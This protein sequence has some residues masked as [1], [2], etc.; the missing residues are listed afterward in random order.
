MRIF[1]VYANDMGDGYQL[2]LDV[3]A[4]VPVDIVKK[5][6]TEV[7]ELLNKIPDADF[8]GE[9]DSKTWNPEDL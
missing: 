6:A 2:E 1:T 4:D 3:P 5:V 9:D 8:P 7:S